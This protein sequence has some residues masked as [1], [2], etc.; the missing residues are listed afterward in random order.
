MAAQQQ[1]QK[2]RQDITKKLHEKN[3]LTDVLAKIEQKT[4][5]DRFFLVA[6]ASWFVQFIFI[7]I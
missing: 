6:G 3:Q 5:V 2:F 1:L 7:E 4:G